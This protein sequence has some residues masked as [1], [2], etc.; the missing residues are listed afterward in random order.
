MCFKEDDTNSSLNGKPLKFV[1]Q[2]TYLGSNISSTKSDVNIRFGKSWTDINSLLSI[3]KSDL[4]DEIR[5]GFFNAVAVWGLL[6]GGTTWALTKRREKTNENYTKILRSV[7]KI[8]WWQHPTQLQL[9][10]HLP[11]ISQTIQVRR[12]RHT[13]H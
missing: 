5:R 8:F 12:A 7:L 2:F 3:W 11:P 10:S 13:G 4:S 1:N 6:C 9:Y